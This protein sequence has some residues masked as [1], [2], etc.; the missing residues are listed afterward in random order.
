MTKQFARSHLIWIYIVCKG[1]VYLGSA[2]Q[3]LKFSAFF[4]LSPGNLE[5]NITEGIIGQMVLSDK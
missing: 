3:G 4:N 1:R 2:G 5:N